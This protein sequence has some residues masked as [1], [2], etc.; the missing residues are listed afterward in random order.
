MSTQEHWSSIA[1]YKKSAL[2]RYSNENGIKE[3]QLNE[4]SISNNLYKI[5]MCHCFVCI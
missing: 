5:G 4:L 1:E 3:H 2:L